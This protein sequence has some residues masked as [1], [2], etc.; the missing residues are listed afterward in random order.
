MTRINAIELNV[1]IIIDFCDVT[2]LTF[3][4]MIDFCDVA[5]L[6]FGAMI[7]FCDVTELTVGIMVDFCDVVKRTVWI[8]MGNDCDV[9]KASTD[10]PKTKKGTVLVYRSPKQTHLNTVHEQLAG[11]ST[12]SNFE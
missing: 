6:T 7:D 3:G 8:V 11:L 9:A 1:G 12:S 2:E 10:G 4:A 5:E